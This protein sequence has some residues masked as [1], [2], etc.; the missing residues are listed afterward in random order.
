MWDSFVRL[1]QQ[2]DESVKA[3]LAIENCMNFDK[4]LWKRVCFC[5]QHPCNFCYHS[6][7][8]QAHL[9]HTFTPPLYPHLFSCWIFCLSSILQTASMQLLTLRL[10]LLHHSPSPFPKS[11]IMHLSSYL[12]VGLL[13]PSISISRQDP[14]STTLQCL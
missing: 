5:P 1:Q 10:N 12:L 14:P 11:S 6:Q 2:Q 8:H 3:L 13:Q 4:H 9:F 7:F